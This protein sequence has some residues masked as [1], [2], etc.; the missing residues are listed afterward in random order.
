MRNDKFKNNFF[1]IVNL[2][3]AIGSLL[4]NAPNFYPLV[5]FF[6][7]KL[8]HSNKKITMKMLIKIYSVGEITH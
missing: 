4:G 2:L 3:I 8:N 1:K 5:N 6:D 7:K